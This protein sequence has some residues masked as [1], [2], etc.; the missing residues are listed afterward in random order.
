VAAAAAVTVWLA[1]TWFAA[2]FIVGLS[3]DP[4]RNRTV[5]G[6]AEVANRVM[7]SAW[8]LWWAS[9]LPRLSR[10]ARLALIGASGCVMV[11]TPCVWLGWVVVRL[12]VG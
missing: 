10:Q 11:S 12:E 8:A 2:V 5:W 4:V 1:I 6:P 9:F 7:L 3:T